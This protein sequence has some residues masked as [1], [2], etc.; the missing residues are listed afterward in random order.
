[1]PH[2]LARQPPD[3]ALVLQPGQEQVKVGLQMIISDECVCLVSGW[4]VVF[5][6]VDFSLVSEPHDLKRNDAPGHNAFIV[7]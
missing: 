4:L 2:G 3:Q 1:L 7:S 6:L 5:R